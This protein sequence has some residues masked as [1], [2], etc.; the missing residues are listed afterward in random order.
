MKDIPCT[1]FVE[2]RVPSI[3]AIKSREK[4]NSDWRKK[5]SAKREKLAEFE[6]FICTIGQKQT[7]T[8]FLFN[9]SSKDGSNSSPFFGG[10]HLS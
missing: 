7:L 1:K 4:N 2:V 8:P 3:V 9:N 10:A 5:L 6:A